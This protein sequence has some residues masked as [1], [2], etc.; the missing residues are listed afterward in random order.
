MY[1]AHRRR[2]ARNTL[3]ATTHRGDIA[4]LTI[5]GP[6]RPSLLFCVARSGDDGWTSHSGTRQRRRSVRCLHRLSLHLL[7]RQFVQ[8]CRGRDVLFWQWRS[9]VRRA[10]SVLLR[11]C[12]VIVA[13]RRLGTRTNRACP[14][15]VENVSR[16][17]AVE[18]QP[19]QRS[20]FEMKSSLLRAV[21][22]DVVLRG[23]AR[24]LDS[25]AGSE[26]TY[27]CSTPTDHLDLHLTQLECE[28]NQKVGGVE[29]ALQF[30]QPPCSAES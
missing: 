27:Q 21:P 13:R 1:L 14:E 23:C 4:S 17:S 16:P 20:P 26:A 18:V 11:L 15:V 12:P 29:R 24:L 7:F 28:S 2:C 19:K 5:W 6:G 9:F 8:R 3:C 10:S 25:S 30:P 22:T